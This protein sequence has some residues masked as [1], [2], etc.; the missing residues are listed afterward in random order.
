MFTVVA[1]S[2]TYHLVSDPVDVT[3]DWAEVILSI[4]ELGQSELVCSQ[5]LPCLAAQG[6]GSS[7]IYL[8]VTSFVENSPRTFEV[9]ARVCRT[10]P[11]GQVV[12]S[13]AVTAGP[14]DFNAPASPGGLRIVKS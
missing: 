1:Q 11:T 10:D 12:C 2:N 13:E 6:D 7:I 9:A 8:D 3:A 14:F 4:P 5:T